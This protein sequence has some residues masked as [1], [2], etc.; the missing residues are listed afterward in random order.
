MAFVQCV[1]VP[2]KLFYGFRYF[3]IKPLFLL[4][5]SLFTFCLDTKSNKKIKAMT[6]TDKSGSGC[7]GQQPVRKEK[8]RYCSINSCR[9]R[10]A[11]ST[12]PLLYIC[13]RCDE[14]F[15]LVMTATDKSGYRKF[16]MLRTA[17]S[18]KTATKKA[19]ADAK[20]L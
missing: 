12:Y 15:R 18:K 16:W 11:Y 1:S 4:G 8:S 10:Y 3:D 5:F 17:T 14:E 20:T 7:W 2:L 9:H 19:F 6:P 13:V